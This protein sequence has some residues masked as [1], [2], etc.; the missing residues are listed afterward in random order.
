V[1]GSTGASPKRDDVEPVELVDEAWL[2]DSTGRSGTMSGYMGDMGSGD[3]VMGMEEGVP[4][5]AA[6]GKEEDVES[7][8]DVRGWGAG[9]GIPNDDG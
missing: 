5:G 7:D 3:E 6:I 2:R 9:T 1:T 8:D 4:S